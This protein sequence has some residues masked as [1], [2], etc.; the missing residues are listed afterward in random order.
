MLLAVPLP[1]RLRAI[2]RSLQIDSAR[3]AWS[4]VCTINSR[5]P[6]RATFSCSYS[7]RV[8]LPF[9]R[10]SLAGNAREGV[11]AGNQE[12]TL[13]KLAPWVFQFCQLLPVR[14]A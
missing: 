5:S 8:K 7:I 11:G 3:G 2:G 13:H 9:Q 1:E 10:G 6:Q 14:L 4:W 12:K